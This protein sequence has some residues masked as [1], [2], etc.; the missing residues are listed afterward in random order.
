[1]TDEDIDTS[2]IPKLGPEFFKNAILLPDTKKPVTIRLDPDV[3]WFFC[4]Q[5]NR[6][7]TAINSVLRKY[8]EA[9]TRNSKQPRRKSN[10]YLGV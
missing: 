6:Y 4:K 3:L 5:G 7:K 1:M 2:D 10:K 9:Q 8:V